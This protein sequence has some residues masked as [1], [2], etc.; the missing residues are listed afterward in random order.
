MPHSEETHRIQFLDKYIYNLRQ[1][2]LI[3]KELTEEEKKKN[4]NE[5]KINKLLPPGSFDKKGKLIN[6]NK[7]DE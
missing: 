6:K 2:N 4:D 7:N 5:N 3:L 1:E